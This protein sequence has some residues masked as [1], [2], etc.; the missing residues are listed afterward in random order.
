MR[1]HLNPRAL[2]EAEPSHAGET[3]RSSSHVGNIDKQLDSHQSLYVRRYVGHF[4]EEKDER[5][6]RVFDPDP[7]GAL[8]TFA[9]EFG[10]PAVP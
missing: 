6:G 9:E 3:A 8:M 4:R 10:C 7:D 5:G 1:I 2:S